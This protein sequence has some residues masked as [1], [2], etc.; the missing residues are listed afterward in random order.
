MGLSGKGPQPGL[1]AY[2][3]IAR[4]DSAINGAVSFLR[5]QLTN[6]GTP[7]T[8]QL[9]GRIQFA[10]ETL[11][12]ITSTPVIVSHVMRAVYPAR[13]TICGG[14]ILSV[15][16]EQRKERREIGCVSTGSSVSRCRLLCL[17]TAP[18][19]VPTPLARPAPRNERAA[20]RSSVSRGA[21]LSRPLGKGG[22]ARYAL[23]R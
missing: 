11:R 21:G 15:V 23:L 10:P 17:E 5:G 9:P 1:R 6:H 13:N 22:S 14:P 18:R 20:S 2:A 19:R 3:A 7:L 16:A 4:L 12:E 8:L